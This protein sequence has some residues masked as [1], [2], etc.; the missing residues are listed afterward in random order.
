MHLSVV[1]P[2]FNEALRIGKTLS[3]ANA[4]L[5]RQCYSSEVLVVDDGSTDNTARLLET[6]F[7]T[8]RTVSYHPHRGKGYAVRKGMPAAT[9][10]Y[11]VFYDADGSTPI[12]EL[13]KLWPR[14]EEGADIVI[15]SRS[16]PGSEVVVRQSWLRQNMGRGFNLMAR[17][18]R[19]TSFPDTQCGFKGFTARACETVFP[20]QTLD[21]FAFDV[22]ILY[23][24]QKHGL[25]VEQVPIRW[26]NSPRSSLN[27][28]TGSFFM[29][30][31]LLR[32]PFADRRGCY[33]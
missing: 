28:V 22:E 10:D 14:F 17:S 24:A 21:G 33:D 8:V 26:I 1:I 30:R 12:E 4:Y 23:I 15:G 20:R 18:L 16:L 13:G 5:S 29:L 2:A 7:P 9:G 32:I 19:L 11:R 25:R 31:E 6:L 27:L 3:E